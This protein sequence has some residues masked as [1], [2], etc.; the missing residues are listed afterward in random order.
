MVWATKRSSLQLRLDN[1]RRLLPSV[2]NLNQLPPRRRPHS[3][4]K[5]PKYGPS[6]AAMFKCGA[7]MG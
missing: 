5:V 3:T 1:I 6:K 7:K 4:F 2:N